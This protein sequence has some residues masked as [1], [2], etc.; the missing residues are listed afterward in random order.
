MV[1]AVGPPGGLLMA[2]TPSNGASR[3][4]IPRS[5]LPRAGSAPPCPLSVTPIRSIPS[6]CRMSIQVSRASACL[7]TLASSSLTVK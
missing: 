2:R 5:P 4:S 6:V 1:T 3:R 7:D